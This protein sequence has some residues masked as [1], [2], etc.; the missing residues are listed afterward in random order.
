MVRGSALLHAVK[1][2]RAREKLQFFKVLSDSSATFQ[3]SAIPP[4][5]LVYRK[6]APY[7]Q[8][9]TAWRKL[10]LGIKLYACKYLIVGTTKYCMPC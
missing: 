3:C 2:E 4:R 1:T 9:L 7:V 6:S 10:A 8:T 5:L